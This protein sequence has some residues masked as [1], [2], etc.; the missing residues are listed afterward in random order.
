[1]LRYGLSYKTILGCKGKN[2]F[3]YYLINGML[4]LFLHSK[5]YVIYILLTFSNTKSILIRLFRQAYNNLIENRLIYRCS[6][7]T[8]QQ[9]LTTFMPYYIYKV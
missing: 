2:F 7:I 5:F 9:R 4:L 1:M 3:L 6:S 8:P